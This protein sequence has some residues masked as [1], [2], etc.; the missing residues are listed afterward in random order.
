ML[1]SYFGNVDMIF[2]GDVYQETPVRE[3]LIFESPKVKVK[4]NFIWVLGRENKMLSIAY[5]NASKRPVVH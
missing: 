3:S 5:K 4:Y 1:T 2:S